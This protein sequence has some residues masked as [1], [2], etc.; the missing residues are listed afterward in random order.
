LHGRPIGKARLDSKAH[1]NVQPRQGDKA[2]SS[3]YNH[4][5]S[6]SRGGSKPELTGNKPRQQKLKF[7]K[8]PF[9]DKSW[10]NF[11]AGLWACS[12]QSTLARGL[13]PGRPAATSALTYLDLHC[14]ALR[15]GA[16]ASDPG[17]CRMCPGT[18][19]EEVRERPPESAAG[20]CASATI[21]A[22]PRKAG[23]RPPSRP[24]WLEA[25]R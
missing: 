18:C 24:G 2:V 7:L 5:L 6:L 22:A 3:L 15:V 20:A 10:N 21:T 25:P 8:F 23:Q 12:A 13:D 16:L 19:R 9:M 11:T 4:Y 1:G 17:S 14:F